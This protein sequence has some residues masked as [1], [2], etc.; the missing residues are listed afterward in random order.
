MSELALFGGPKAIGDNNALKASWAQKGLETALSEYTGAK[1]VKAVGTGTG[2]IISSLFAV[3]CGPGDEV[4]TVAYTW[5]A[6]VGSILR[7]NA[8][9]IFVDIDPRT[10]TMDAEDA[11]RKITPQTKATQKISRLVPTGER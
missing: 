5:V 9:P 3:G 10:L 1:Y 6:T 7:V 11:R 2:A 4:L 8:V